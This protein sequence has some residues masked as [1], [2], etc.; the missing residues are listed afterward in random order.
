MF[1]ATNIDSPVSLTISDNVQYPFLPQFSK[2]LN[3][4][5]QQ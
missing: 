3:V 5:L 4:Y 2:T 1:N